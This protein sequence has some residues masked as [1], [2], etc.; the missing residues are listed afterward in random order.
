MVPRHCWRGLLEV[1]VGSRIVGPLL[2]VNLCVKVVPRLLTNGAL[3][4][5]SLLDL[6]FR[7]RSSL[8][9]PAGVTGESNP[10]FAAKPFS[11]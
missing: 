1:R 5:Y 9:P 2:G 3:V 11:P 6:E 4:P 7:P 8:S 10:E